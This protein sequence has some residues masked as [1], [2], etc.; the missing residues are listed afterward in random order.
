MKNFIIGFKKQKLVGA[1]NICT[2]SLGI[3]VAVVVG[4]WTINELSFDRFHKNKD[5]IY[6][7]ILNVNLSGNPVKSSGTFRPF[8]EQA[9]DELPAIENI[10]RILYDNSGDIRIDN[11]LYQ[12]VETLM[13][14][15]N[16]FTFFT[17]SLKAGDPNQVL[18]SPDKVVI[19][20]S[21]AKKYF[22]GQDPMGQMIRFNGQDFAVSGIMKDM[23]KNSSLKTDLVF[24]FF[25]WWATQDWGN[26]DAYMA[27]LLLQ[28]GVAP[29]TLE[30]PLTQLSYRKIEMFKNF[31]ATFTLESLSDMH[32]SQGTMF[33]P[34][35][36]GNKSLIMVFV[37]TALVILIISC[38]NFANLF[39]STSFIR[40]KTIGIK[41]TVGA[42]NLRLMREFYS[43]TACYVL[44]SIGIGLIL[45]TTVIP[46]F[47]NFTQATVSLD[48]TTPQI[49]VFLA[50]IFVLV[51]LLAGSFPA[52]V[53]TRFNILETLKG[54]FKGKKMSLLQKSL[55]ITQFAAS[56]ALLIVVA[57]MQKQVNYILAYDLGFNKEN[58]IYVHGRDS[59]TQNYKALE[60]EFLQEP[61]IT[62]VSRKNA[63]PT[64]WTQGM[65]FKGVPWDN[66]QQP[67]LME[68][69]RVHPNYFDFFDMKIIDGENP[70][71]LEAEDLNEVVINESAAR[72]LGYENPVGELI[73]MD[74][75]GNQRF[76]IRGMVRNAHTKSL[77]QEVDPQVYFKLKDDE[78]WSPRIFFKVS[79]D[80]Q[81]AIAFIEQK[82]KEREAEYP[83]SYHFLDETYQQLYTSEM[84]AGKVF[85]FAM[86][87]SLMIT[88]A[89]LFAMAYYATQRRM[90]EVA[91][92][93]V[94]GASLKD[95]FVLLNKSF[96]IWVG[97]AFA[98][99]CPVAYYALHQWLEGF[100]V[101]TP[102]SAW[103]FLLVGVVALLV[104][105]LTTVYQTWKVATANPVKYLKTE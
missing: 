26:M 77:H 56:I 9:K 49:Y 64:E 98:I 44:L 37:A 1:L 97:I 45:A 13:C 76:P 43:E 38:I 78:W 4:L 87:I 7:I 21:A 8:S 80:P 62:A 71:F 103:V 51:V 48:F 93:K 61:S 84:N 91:I 23:P 63:L 25:G 34:I 14:D 60:G 15:S 47:N 55:V 6:R 27:F 104:T 31:G 88:V 73:E 65:S 105:L 79:G 30:E 42:K 86:L 28:E 67:I 99:A 54:K 18:S 16:F 50:A 32:F 39:V 3:M 17:F 20:E 96:V 24:P 66:T 74:G 52:L 12:S 85:N 5:R 2:L 101:K 82:W 69:C 70:F 72:M 36:K 90:K 95:I 83:F 10:C 68:C 29:E 40:A 94:Y 57:F 41:K 89:G 11:V 92:R 81:R 75:F 46:T 102:L 22:A 19:S 35:V 33:D 59:W 100:V 53:M 58:V